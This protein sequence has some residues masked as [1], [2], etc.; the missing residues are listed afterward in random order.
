M[1]LND[2]KARIIINAIAQS[3]SPGLGGSAAGE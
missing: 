2:D 1:L 3:P